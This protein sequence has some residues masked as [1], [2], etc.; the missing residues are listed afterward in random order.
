M[1][2]GILGMKWGVRRYQNYDGSLTKAGKK[3]YD[4]GNSSKENTVNKDRTPDGKFTETYKKS[5]YEDARDNDM[6]NLEFLEAVQNKAYMHADTP[7]RKRQLLSEYKRFL[8]DP[9]NYIP[10]GEDE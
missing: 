5:A 1:H 9:L 6:F 10:E 2:F 4:D 8:N 7:E 3:R